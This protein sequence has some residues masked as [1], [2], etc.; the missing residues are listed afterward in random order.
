M[1]PQEERRQRNSPDPPAPKQPSR[2]KR[3]S[4]PAKMSRPPIACMAVRTLRVGNTRRQS[5]RRRGRRPLPRTESGEPKSTSR[6]WPRSLRIAARPRRPRPPEAPRSTMWH[7]AGQLSQSARSMRA[8]LLS[9][10]KP[11]RPRPGVMEPRVSD[12]LRKLESSS[13][14]SPKRGISSRSRY[15][16]LGGWNADLGSNWGP[17]LSSFLGRTGGW[18][19]QKLVKPA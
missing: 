17:S 14:R 10:D 11:H 13:C 18:Q 12:K 7:P 8:T 2:P 5:W 15:P 3:R 1:R 19:R 16:L 4:E 6:C 9:R